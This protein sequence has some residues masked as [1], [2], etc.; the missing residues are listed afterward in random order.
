MKKRWIKHRAKPPE[1]EITFSPHHLIP[2]YR[3]I[4]EEEIRAICQ[5]LH[6][7]WE[8]RKKEDLGDLIHGYATV[9]EKPG[10]NHKPH[11]SLRLLL[12][13][14][15]EQGNGASSFAYAKESAKLLRKNEWFRDLWILRNWLTLQDPITDHGLPEIGICDMEDAMAAD[16]IESRFDCGGYSMKKFRRFRAKYRLRQVPKEFKL[17]GIRKVT[18]GCIHWEITAIG[19]KTS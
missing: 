9:K 1:D 19:G 14:Q 8:T 17:R 3:G 13:D 11:P 7:A 2:M 6:N 4:P 18:H 5:S 12:L 15:I 16:I 10:V